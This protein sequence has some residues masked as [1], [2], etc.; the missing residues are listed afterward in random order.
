MVMSARADGAADR[1]SRGGS[2][3]CLNLA[4][5][6]SRD[7]HEV[8]RSMTSPD[9]SLSIVAPCFNEQTVLPEFLARMRAVVDRLGT[10]YK[11]F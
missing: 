1:P 6:A 2:P 8:P 7:Q 11:I 3:G 10:G 5:L 9:S 4:D